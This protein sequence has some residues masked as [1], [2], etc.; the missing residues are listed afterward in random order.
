MI[1]SHAKLV[2]KTMALRLAPRMHELVL[3]NQNA[4]IRGRTI[5][6]NFKFF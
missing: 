4:F 5:H 2:S 1:H 6:D 3:P